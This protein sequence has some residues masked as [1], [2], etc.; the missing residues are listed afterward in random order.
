VALGS[1]QVL[2]EFEALGDMF[3]SSERD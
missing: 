3:P 2:E 1:G